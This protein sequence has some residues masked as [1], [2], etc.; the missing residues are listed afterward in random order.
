RK[1]SDDLKACVPFLYFREGYRVKDICRILGLGKTLVYDCIRN[2]AQHHPA[3]RPHS[4][5]QGRRR[6]VKHAHVN[7]ICQ[8]LSAHHSHYLDELQTELFHTFNIH[9]SLPTLSQ[10][11]RW[12][13]LSPSH[14]CLTNHLL[15]RN[16][17]LR[18]AFWNRV[19]ELVTDLNQLMFTDEAAK[20]D[21]THCRT[22]GYSDVGTQCAER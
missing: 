3:N 9:I 10:T 20:D 2:H 21:R 14:Q 16:E 12:T 1:K 13:S 7:F 18:A 5:P 15:E 11:L 19:A 4:L 17:T 6:I 22:H 8:L